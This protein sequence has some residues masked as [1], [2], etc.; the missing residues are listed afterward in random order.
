V[1]SAKVM[2]RHYLT[3]GHG[4]VRIMGIDQGTDYDSG[5]LRYSFRKK[6]G[7]AWHE[8]GSLNAAQRDGF[9]PEYVDRNLDVVYGMKTVDGRLAAY[10]IALDGSGTER[11]LLARTDVDVD[12]FVTIGRNRRVIGISYTTDRNQVTYLDPKLEAIVGALS[13]AMPHLP[14]IRLVDASEDEKKLLIWAS[15]DVDPGRYYVLDRATNAMEEVAVNRLPLEQV[16]LASVKPVSFP[17]ADGTI[18]PGYL[19]LPPG[20]DGKNLPSIVLPHGG[21]SAR[22]QWGFDWLAQYWAH[23]GYAVLQPNFRGSSGFGDDW[24]QKNGIQSWKTA[25]GDVTDAGRWLVTQGIADPQKLGIFGWSYGGYAAL[26]A[27]AIAPGLFRAI[28]AVAPVTDF[29]TLRQDGENW[30]SY[31]VTSAFIGTG[32]HIREGSPAQR[33]GEIRSP[34]LLFHGDLD[35]NVDIGH[36]RLM[37]E[38]LKAASKDHELITYAG[39]D[40]YLDD[41]NTRKDMLL[42]SASFMDKAFAAP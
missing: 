11:R 41:S 26:Q 7:D 18:I 31:R 5:V 36:S 30:S 22:D 37:A 28:V 12:G 14:L 35:R 2:A 27:G 34:V 38:R 20:S 23:L 10:S 21:P 1:E 40:H 25:V 39:L 29:E 4:R 8:L 19:T 33:A 42:R 24:L 32:P 16:A 13:K 6:T 9:A 3:D 15:S 17:A